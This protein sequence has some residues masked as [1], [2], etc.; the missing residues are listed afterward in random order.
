[1]DDLNAQLAFPPYRANA[2]GGAKA[3]LVAE[4]FEHIRIDMTPQF[5]EEQ[6]S[7]WFGTLVGLTYH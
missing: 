5:E 1:M 4:G 7:S 3:V 2:R 6:Y